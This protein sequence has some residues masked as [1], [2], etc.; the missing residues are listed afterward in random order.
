[1][2]GILKEKGLREHDPFEAI[3]MD[4][5]VLDM[6]EAKD[7]EHLVNLVGGALAGR[8]GH[9]PSVFVD[10]F[11]EGTLKGATPVAKGV[12]L[13][14]MHLEDIDGPLLALVRVRKELRFLAG[15]VFGKTAMT[16]GVHAA[17]FLVSPGHDPAQHLRLLAQLASRIDQE[18]FL[19]HWLAAESELALREVFLRD[20]RYV[21][22]EVTEANRAAAWVGMEL[23]ELGLPE[24]CL[25][26][27]LR[28]G[29][30]TLVPRGHTRLEEGDKL[31]IFGEPEVIAGLYARF[32]GEVEEGPAV[33][34]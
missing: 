15:D 2:R 10:G 32:E 29:G 16:E 23:R 28:R 6:E 3:V 12:A 25:V 17:F 20:D 30:R 1:M 19:E 9:S 26:A 22:V 14:H 4:A 21:S 27:A 24:G 5:V 8:S 18:D 11:T 13:P 33:A 7:F 34:N 31:L